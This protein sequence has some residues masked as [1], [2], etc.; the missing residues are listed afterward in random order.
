MPSTEQWFTKRF[1]RIISNEVHIPPYL[2]EI[3][4]PHTL[5]RKPTII[6]EVPTE[7]TTIQNLYQQQLPS[8]LIHRQNH[9]HIRHAEHLLHDIHDTLGKLS[10][11][12]LLQFL[13][14]H[15]NSS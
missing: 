13:L 14:H 6:R 3:L 4:L 15:I 5:M 11:S 1:C 8:L 2:Q 12:Q 10:Q 9:L 7:V